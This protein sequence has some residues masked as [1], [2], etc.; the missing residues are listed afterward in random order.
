MNL[1]ALLTA[2]PR[3]LTLD[4]PA[5]SA[6]YELVD[7]LIASHGVDHDPA[8]VLKL[9]SEGISVGRT[10]AAKTALASE[11]GPV[12]RHV[13]GGKLAVPTGRVLVRFGEGDLAVDHEADLGRAGFEVEEV[14]SY[15]PHAA[16]VR[17]KGGGVVDALRGL[18]RLAALT[19]LH[20]LEP[21]LI[22]E[23]QKR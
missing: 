4:T 22:A 6:R 12:Y 15:A 14:L 8:P 1:E 2:A 7:D 23:Q 19:G 11:L 5:G 21:Q 16:W 9:E 10:G 13:P 17:P 18:E 3:S 20:H